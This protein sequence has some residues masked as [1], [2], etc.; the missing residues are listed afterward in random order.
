MDSR[1]HELGSAVSAFGT[2]RILAFV[3]VSGSIPSTRLLDVVI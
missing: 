2:A 1:I 3:H